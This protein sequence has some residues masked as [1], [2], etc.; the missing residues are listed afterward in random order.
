MWDLIIAFLI[1]II[2]VSAGVFGVLCI[3]S[4]LIKE[5]MLEGYRSFK[6]IKD[7]E[8]KRIASLNK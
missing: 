8:D 7:Q 2:I 4:V 5:I 6:Y 3:L 1:F